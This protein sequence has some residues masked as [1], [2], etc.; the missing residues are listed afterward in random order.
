MSEDWGSFSPLRLDDGEIDAATAS[1]SLEDDTDAQL[2]EEYFKK[3]TYYVA[4]EPEGEVRTPS[5]LTI[6]ARAHV[7]ALAVSPKDERSRAHTNDQ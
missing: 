5:V 7:H 1:A 2:L 6:N 4:S 3:L